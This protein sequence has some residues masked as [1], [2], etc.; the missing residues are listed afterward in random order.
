M[1]RFHRTGQRPCE[2]VSSLRLAGLRRPDRAG[3][4][5][6]AYCEEAGMNR[7]KTTP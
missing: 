2:D 7:G 5:R 1:P 6:R 4:P 3:N